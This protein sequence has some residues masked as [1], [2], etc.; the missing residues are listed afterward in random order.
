MFTTWRGVR[1]GGNERANSEAADVTP[2]RTSSG[3][4]EPSALI[5]EMRT[6]AAAENGMLPYEFGTTSTSVSLSVKK[7]TRGPAKP[8]WARRMGLR[9]Y[10]WQMPAL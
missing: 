7:R 6:T 1:S 5:A 8:W 10:G 9:T 3:T 2:V 4:S